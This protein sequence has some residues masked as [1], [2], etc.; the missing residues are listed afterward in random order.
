MG[1]IDWYKEM[2][3]RL[4]LINDE[5]ILIVK[6]ED[7]VNYNEKYINKICDFLKLSSVVSSSY[8]VELS[9]KNVYK[10]RYHKDK[11]EIQLIENHLKDYIKN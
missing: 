1:F 11:K 6:F 4:K 8:N 10:F 9:K 5:N 7:F 3:K 2:Q